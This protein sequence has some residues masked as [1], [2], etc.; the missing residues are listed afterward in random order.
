MDLRPLPRRPKNEA[1]YRDGPSVYSTGPRG[2][3]LFGMGGMGQMAP[4]TAVSMALLAGVAVSTGL[5]YFLSKPILRKQATIG[6][7]L[8]FGLALNVGQTILGS[9]IASAINRTQREA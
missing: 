9:A 7:S 4:G 5:V 6:Q 8:G 3:E 2:A 1:W